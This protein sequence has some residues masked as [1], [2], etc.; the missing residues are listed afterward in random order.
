M[1]DEQWRSSQTTRL[2]GSSLLVLDLDHTLVHTVDSS[3]HSTAGRSF[4]IGSDLRTY[5]RPHVHA[6]F[7]ALHRHGIPYAVWTAGTEDYAA[8]IVS[9]LRRGGPFRPRFV[10]N[11]AQTTGP[12]CVK[13]L[14]KVPGYPKV[15][16]VDDSTHH[17]RLH[18]NHGRVLIVPPFTVTTTGDSFF[19]TLQR[20][21]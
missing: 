19:R 6:F 13:D 20:Q 8:S 1:R 2:D 3:V 21:L 15:L 9:V 16:L 7:R 18:A 5:V 17:L 4:A 10:W 11:R 14:S 12:E